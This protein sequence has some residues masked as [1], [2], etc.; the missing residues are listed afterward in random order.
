[1]N[2]LANLGVLL[3][4]RGRNQEA[5]EYL[6]AAVS[7]R[8]KRL[9]PEH[10]KTHN[11]RRWLAEAEKALTE[12]AGART[13]TPQP[14]PDTLEPQ[15]TG[16]VSPFSWCIGRGRLPG[17]PREPRARPC[18]RGGGKKFKPSPGWWCGGRPP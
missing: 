15:A 3:H 13:S 18:A 16:V 5:R 9:G 10:E 17:S 2:S 6:S 8:E 4:Q 12:G 14:E 1:A 11:A 7:I